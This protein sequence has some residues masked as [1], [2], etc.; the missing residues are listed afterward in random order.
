MLVED[1]IMQMMDSSS[2]ELC[3][4]ELVNLLARLTLHHPLD[5]ALIFAMLLGENMEERF[6]LLSS[7][8]TAY[9]RN[10]ISK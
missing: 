9:R 10:R 4:L 6:L 7:W 3:V 8:L 2:F 1:T 5:A